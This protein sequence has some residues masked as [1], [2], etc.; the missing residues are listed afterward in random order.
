MARTRMAPFLLALLLP[1][2]AARG[3]LFVDECLNADVTLRD[4][5]AALTA[6]RA[7]G[8]SERATAGSCLTRETVIERQLLACPAHVP[9]RLAA[10]AL[11]IEARQTSRAQQLLDEVL[12]AQP[13]APDA[14]A[15]RARLAVDEGNLPFARRLLSEQVVLSPTHPG[16]RETLA[17][18]FYLSGQL[19]AARDEL[20][21]AARLGAPAWRVAYHTGLV[22]EA[23]GRTMQAAQSYRDAVAANPDA[24][25]ARARLEA[26]DLRNRP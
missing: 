6:A 23:A 22:E 10:A 13:V 9:T 5:V 3:P 18:V 8:C 21:A 14:A 20:R 17:S 16:L 26:L 19:D 25:Q 15:I 2:C 12:T 24:E 11:A 4:T 1:A 7:A